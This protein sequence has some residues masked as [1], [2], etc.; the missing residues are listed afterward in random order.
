[1]QCVTML[2]RC[3]HIQTTYDYEYDYELVYD[4][5]YG[6]VFAYVYV[7]EHEY[8][9]VYEC[10]YGREHECEYEREYEYEHE[11]EQ[12]HVSNILKRACVPGGE[13]TVVAGVLPRQHP[14]SQHLQDVWVAE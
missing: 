9:Y 8:E 6:Y 2:M 4:H 1:M 12:R 5:E 14:D 11:R 3:R 10:E 13:H 7:S